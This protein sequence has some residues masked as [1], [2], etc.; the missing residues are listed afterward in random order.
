MFSLLK[1]QYMTEFSRIGF[2]DK[3]Y[4]GAFSTIGLL[5]RQRMTE[6]SRVSCLDEYYSS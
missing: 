3:H 1:R 2:R 6:I 4:R 5:K